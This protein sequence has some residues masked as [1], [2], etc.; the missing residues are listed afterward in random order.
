MSCKDTELVNSDCAHCQ[1]W[2]AHSATIIEDFDVP[3]DVKR[4]VTHHIQNTPMGWKEQ[5]EPSIRLFER[6]LI[7]C[8]PDAWLELR[9]EMGTS[10]DKVVLELLAFMSLRALGGDTAVETA[11]LALIQGAGQPQAPLFS[12]KDQAT[13]W[14]D[15]AE[16][17]E[18]EAYCL[19][20]FKKMSP[21]RQAKFLE[22]VSREKRHNA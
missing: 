20:S 4:G 19:A 16:P 22:Y 2:Q 6:A 5:H 9:L 17:A 7:L 8:T 12:F 10:L 13:Y 1:V 3:P 18:L 21:A 14:A 11:H 15:M